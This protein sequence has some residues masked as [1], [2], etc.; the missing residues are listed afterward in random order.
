MKKL[1]IPVTNDIFKGEK[2]IPLVDTSSLKEGD[3]IMVRNNKQLMNNVSKAGEIHFISKVSNNSITLTEP[4]WDDYKNS[5]DLNIDLIKPK[6]NISITGGVIEGNGNLASQFSAMEFKYVK[7]VQISNTHIKNWAERGIM[8]S[9]VVYGVIEKNIFENIFDNTIYQ[10]PTGYSVELSESTQWVDTI[11]NFALNVNKLWD[12]SGEA[13]RHGHTRFCKV[14][15]NKVYGSMR[16]AISTHAC[17]EYFDI[18]GNTIYGSNNNVAGTGHSIYLRTPNCK[19]YDNLIFDSTGNGIDVRTEGR[20]GYFEIFNNSV[21][22]SGSHGI[23]VAPS[24]TVDRPND[25]GIL[26]HAKIKDNYIENSLNGIFIT[27][28]EKQNG[29][30]KDIIID[31]NHI[32][33]NNNSGITITSSNINFND[34]N[35][36]NNIIESDIGILLNPAGGYFINNPFI[37]GNDIT[38]KSE[39]IKTEIQSRTVEPFI[40]G[41]Y[42]KSSIGISG[43]KD[44]DII[45]N[46]IIIK[47]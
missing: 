29:D 34:I 32:K 15:N 12:V 19:I 16:G 36:K 37:F 33:N 11:N 27:G 41:N 35:I 45:N 1:S 22:N 6:E 25:D 18:I 46:K 40:N 5:L 42:I 21:I 2:I 8:L 17:G 14:I 47:E 38:A 23:R 30:T 20:K 44:D 26:L 28:N 3:M 24:N 39:G 9:S 43:F 7:N 4:L 31:G 13:T 10:P